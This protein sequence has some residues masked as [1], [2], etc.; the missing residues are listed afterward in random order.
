MIT[1]MV[2]GNGRQYCNRLVKQLTFFKQNLP[3]PDY[4]KLAYYTLEQSIP[5]PSSVQPGIEYGTD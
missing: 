3:W 2:P 1:L 5:G 4:S